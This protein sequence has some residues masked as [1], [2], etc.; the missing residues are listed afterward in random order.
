MSEREG[1]AGERTRVSV[2]PWCTLLFVACAVAVELSP[3]GTHALGFERASIARGEVWRLLSGHLVHGEPRLALLDLATL[4]LFGAWVERA[5]R[6]LFGA[7]LAMSAVISS[8]A[9]YGLTD[10]A[11]YVGSSALVSGL[12]VA[13]VML[14]LDGARRRS[15]GRARVARF[16]ALAL[17]GLFVGK[18]VLELFGAW[19]AALGGLPSGYEPVAVAH[20]GGA[21]GG[22]SA[23]F[24]RRA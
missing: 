17:L 7:V 1:T 22:F 9:V 5:S 24:R 2:L 10:Y 23:T 19:P 20:A 13:T 16:A 8:L 4:A 11:R 18:V 14:L 21:L 6:P 15:S 12:L 3:R